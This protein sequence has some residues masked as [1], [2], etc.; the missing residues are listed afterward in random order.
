MNSLMSAPAE[1]VKMLLDAITTERISV[2]SSQCFHSSPNSWISCGLSGFA[3]R[4][5]EPDD[6]DSP[7][8][9]SSTVSFCSN[10]GSG[11]G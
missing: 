10:P 11:C 4:P 9:S 7:R 2:L 3:G 5:V 8:V 6:R 1:N